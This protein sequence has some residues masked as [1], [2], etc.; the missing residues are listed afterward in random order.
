MERWEVEDSARVDP[1]WETGFEVKGGVLAAELASVT[2]PIA[3]GRAQFQASS[4][5]CWEARRRGVQKK[6]KVPRRKN[7]E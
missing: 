5:L 6:T 3:Q 7:A 4:E 2:Q 1:S